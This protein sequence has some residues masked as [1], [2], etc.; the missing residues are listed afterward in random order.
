MPSFLSEPGPLIRAGPGRTRIERAVS[1]SDRTQTAGFVPGS[2]V[3]CLLVIYSSEY[4][5][6]SE[7][8]WR[9]ANVVGNGSLRVVYCWFG[10]VGV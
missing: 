4:W 9:R 8:G 7:A 1:G 10:G 5:C 3:S 2:R 6:C